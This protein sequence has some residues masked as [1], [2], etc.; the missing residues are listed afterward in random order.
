MIVEVRKNF[1]VAK[2]PDRDPPAVFTIKTQ[3]IL[4]NLGLNG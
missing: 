2:D 1:L 4:V 3:E